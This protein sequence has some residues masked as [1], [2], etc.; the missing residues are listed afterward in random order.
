MI[1]TQP[2]T[3]LHHQKVDDFFLLSPGAQLVHA[4][5]GERSLSIFEYL[6]MRRTQRS[7]SQALAPAKLQNTIDICKLL[8]NL[9]ALWGGVITYLSI[10]Y[11]HRTLSLAHQ[12]VWLHPSPPLILLEKLSIFL[13]RL[14]FYQ[15]GFRRGQ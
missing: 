6:G 10:S 11:Q 1:Y 3:H 15:P 13:I 14:P 8:I 9:F 7:L 4:T 2:P 12:I 5:T